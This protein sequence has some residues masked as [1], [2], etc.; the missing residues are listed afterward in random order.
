MEFIRSLLLN[1]TV[2]TNFSSVSLTSFKE[3][4]W[5]LVVEITHGDW[6][7]AYDHVKTRKWINGA[8][9]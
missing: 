5:K 3:V 9:N 2:A 8:S 7:K 4:T 1:K 6:K